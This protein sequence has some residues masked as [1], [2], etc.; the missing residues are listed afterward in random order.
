MPK[1]LQTRILIAD[2]EQAIL[3]EYASVLGGNE[4]VIQAKESRSA[5]E[6]ELFGDTEIVENNAS[7]NY[8][9]TLC[10]QGEIAVEKVRAAID[11]G[12]PYSVAFLD[13]RM[14]PGISGVETAKMIREI[15][16]NLNI[17]FITGYSDIKPSEF[18]QQVPPVDKLLY[19]QKPIKPDELTQFAHA[20]SAKWVSDRSL[21]ANSQRMQHLLSSS[22]SVIYSRS[23][24]KFSEFNYVSENSRRL[25]GWE[26]KLF[27]EDP[28]F[29]ITKVHPDDLDQLKN[30]I[31]LL[32]SSEIS[33]VEYRFMH[34]DGE[35]R[36]INDESALVYDD[37]NYPLE[38]VGTWIDLTSEKE[39]QVVVQH[40]ALHDTLTDLPNRSLLN[41]RL[42]HEVD[43]AKRSGEPFALILI[44]LDHFK[45]VNDT[46]GHQAGDTLLKQVAIRLKKQIREVDTLARLGGDEFAVLLPAVSALEN[47]IEISDR[48]LNAMEEHFKIEGMML[49][50][51]MSAG[52]ALYPEHAEQAD[53][54]LRCADVAM[55]MAKANHGGVQLYDC[56][57]DNNSL[58]RL[59]VSGELRNAVENDQL[60]FHYQPKINLETKQVCGVEALARWEHEEYGFV[61]PDEFIIHAERSGLI[62]PLTKWALSTAIKQLAEWKKQGVEI[63]ISVNLSARNLSDKGLP[64]LVDSLLKEWDILP[65]FLTLEITESAIMKDSENL[66]NVLHS[67]DKLG[68]NLSIDDFGTGYSSLAYLKKLPVDELKIDRSFVVSMLKNESDPIIVQSTIDLAH[69]LGYRVVAEGIESAEHIE[70]LKSFGCDIGQGYF[71]NKPVTV[72]E[73]TAWLLENSYSHPA[74]TLDVTESETT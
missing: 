55:Y 30:H 15:D 6:A 65:H 27:I 41:D 18:G 37:N 3:D 59:A 44:D 14:P 33:R 49:E 68:V 38:H 19:C 32:S 52:I 4:S 28:D 66:L 12:Q 64:I 7:P 70:V 47:A 72:G 39:H 16:A 22:P 43:V 8:D 58:R 69:N 56:S 40:L 24:S 2:D 25:L 46:L 45:E 60:T 11:E 51:G 35:Y 48:M 13:V 26:A 62:Q 23:A 34:K 42:Q 17:V 67:L 71:I 31:S 21:Q 20:L 50:V 61:P 74:K 57:R 63:D 29:W 9:V 5:L 10:R 36:W 1:D 54:L 53:L 73:M